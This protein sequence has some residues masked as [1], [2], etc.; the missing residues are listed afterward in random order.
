MGTFE[1]SAITMPMSKGREKKK[2]GNRRRKGRALL[3]ETIRD[4]EYYREQRFKFDD[5]QTG[6]VSFQIFRL[7]R[8][9]FKK[10]IEKK[11]NDSLIIV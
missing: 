3:L 7:E 6:R 4:R 5:F 8:M 10:S 9:A 1:R 11:R 2:K